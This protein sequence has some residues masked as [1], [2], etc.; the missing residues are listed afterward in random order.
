MSNGSVWVLL[1]ILLC[2]F[3]NTASFMVIEKYLL[4]SKTLK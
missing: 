4:K 1:T 2:N 3:K